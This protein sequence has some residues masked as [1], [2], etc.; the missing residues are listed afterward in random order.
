MNIIP[1]KYILKL[2]SKHYH[3]KKDNTITYANK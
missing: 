2:E 1:E 3:E